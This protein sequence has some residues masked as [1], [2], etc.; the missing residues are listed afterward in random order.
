MIVMVVIMS[1]LETLAR[2]S[3]Q[4][5]KVKESSAGFFPL[6]YFVFHLVCSFIFIIN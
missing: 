4:F 2:L 6:G 3:P 1:G 5:S